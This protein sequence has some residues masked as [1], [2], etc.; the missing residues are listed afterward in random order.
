MKLPQAVRVYRKRVVRLALI[1]VRP[2]RRFVIVHYHI[3]KNGGSTIEWILEREF[4]RNFTT[5]HGPSADSILDGED[6]A[7][8]LR[9]H[10]PIA[11]VSSHHL[12]YPLP[13]VAEFV[14]FDCCF[15]RH[16]LSRLNSL[17]GQFRRANPDHPLGRLAQCQNQRAF[18]K[19]LVD[20]SPNMVSEVQVQQLA[21]GGVFRR[22]ADGKDLKRAAKVVREMA[23]PGLVEMFDQSLVANEYFLRPAFP[24]LELAYIPR[25]VGNFAPLPADAPTDALIELW[26]QDL[27]HELLRLNELDL[28][29]Y[30]RTA[31]EIERRFSLVPES[32]RRLVDF[33]ARCAKLSA[34]AAEPQAEKAPAPAL[35]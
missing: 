30:E 15:L 33:R 29:L 10:P 21:N 35:I 27:Y 17:Y 28:E 19:S 34:V 1:L 23:M 22:P 18:L 11:A 20:H 16:P 8:F 4:A 9:Q 26:G 2:N 7:Q 5:L 3:F 13:R 31:E 14:F 24:T 12:R 32:G 6:L 25:N